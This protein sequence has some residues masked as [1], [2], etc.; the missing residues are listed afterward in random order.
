MFHDKITSEEED[1]IIIN[2]N[3]GRDRN[4]RTHEI[5]DGWR[6]PS[7]RHNRSWHEDYHD[8]DNYYWHEK[9]S[10]RYHR[11]R[12]GQSFYLSSSDSD[13]HNHRQGGMQS[14]IN[15]KPTSSVIRQLKYPHFSLS[16]QTGYIGT[17]IQFHQLKTTRDPEERQGTMELLH[18]I[19]LWRLRAGITWQQV[20]NTHV[21]ILQKSKIEKSPEKRTGTDLNKTS[22]TRSSSQY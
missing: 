5:Y 1:H 15:A 21:H 22:M 16:Q 20:R 12:S 7:N 9:A 8:D 6:S 14:G 13:Y 17:N 3:R 4:C 11:R 2:N 18:R 19:T 10:R